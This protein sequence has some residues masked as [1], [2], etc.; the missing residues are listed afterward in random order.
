VSQAEKDEKLFRRR[1]GG[2]E[3]K[4]LAPA[5]L[6]GECLVKTVKSSCEKLRV[7]KSHP[8]PREASFNYL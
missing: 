6:S 8:M 7:E 2:G 5:V 3:V 4:N 1:G